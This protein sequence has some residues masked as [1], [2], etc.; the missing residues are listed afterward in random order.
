MTDVRGLINRCPHAFTLSASFIIQQ[1]Y[2]CILYWIANEWDW[3]PVVLLLVMKMSNFSLWVWRLK[4]FFLPHH[5]ELHHCFSWLSRMC[6]LHLT[7]CKHLHFMFLSPLVISIS[8][9]CLMVWDSLV[10]RS[11]DKQPI[12]AQSLDYVFREQCIRIQQ[13]VIS[14][15]VELRWRLWAF[16]KISIKNDAGHSAEGRAAKSQLKRIQIQ[17]CA[18]LSSHHENT[19][20]FSHWILWLHITTHQIGKYNNGQQTQ[21]L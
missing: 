3:C 18:C 8:G 21:L 5:Q 17:P 4:S 19:I 7:H 9:I 2:I 14:A 11:H 1:L 6:N 15:C 12:S 10:N 20:M 13:Y 16:N